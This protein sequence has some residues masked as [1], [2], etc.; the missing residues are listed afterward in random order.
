MG[1]TIGV[2]QSTYMYICF[3]FELHVYSHMCRLVAL[4]QKYIFLSY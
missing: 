4:F 1:N 2:E 3:Y